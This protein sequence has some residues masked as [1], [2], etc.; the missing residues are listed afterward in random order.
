MTSTYNICFEICF[1]Y[2]IAKF[3]SLDDLLYLTVEVNIED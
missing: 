1:H 2:V 3:I